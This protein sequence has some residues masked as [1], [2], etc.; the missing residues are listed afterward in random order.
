MIARGS[1]EVVE[2][3]GRWSMLD[4]FVD[5]FVVAPWRNSSR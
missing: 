1:H 5:A 4:V 3:V 2:F